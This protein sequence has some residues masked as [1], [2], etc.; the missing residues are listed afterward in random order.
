M[1]KVATGWN[2]MKRASMLH[3]QLQTA[4]NA[5]EFE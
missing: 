1:N 3:L 5:N 2:M 4:N